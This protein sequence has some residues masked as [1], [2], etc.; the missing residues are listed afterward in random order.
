[1]GDAYLPVVIKNLPA[2]FVFQPDGALRDKVR[3]S[4]DM[5]V[6]KVIAGPEQSH[7]VIDI[8]RPYCRALP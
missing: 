8:A 6:T 7:L 3:R 2:H 4:V 5:G 1:M